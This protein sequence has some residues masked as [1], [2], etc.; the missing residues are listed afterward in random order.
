MDVAGD[1][2]EGVDRVRIV[3]NAV[4]ILT[5]ASRGWD[6]EE[7]IHN[8]DTASFCISAM[9]MAV[10]FVSPSSSSVVIST[11]SVAAAACGSCSSI[12]A[13]DRI[14]SSYSVRMYPISTGR[15]CKNAVM[16]EDS[17]AITP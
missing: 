9:R 10:V 1:V 3:S 15:N 2:G 14:S 16:V 6:C 5:F 17:A 8:I 11:L 12:T 13:H 7:S 4:H